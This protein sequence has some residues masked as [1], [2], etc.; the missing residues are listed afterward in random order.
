MLISGAAQPRVSR[1]ILQKGRVETGPRQFRRYLDIALGSLHEL[2]AILE[3]VGALEYL[4]E[5]ELM[6]MR[7][8]RANCARMV[9]ELLR[10]MTERSRR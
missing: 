4:A 8:S 6:D 7:T 1:S 2:E 9:S 10:K 5:P 3:I